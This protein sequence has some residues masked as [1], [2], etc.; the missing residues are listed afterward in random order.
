MIQ[1]L[2]GPNAIQKEGLDNVTRS[3]TKT[4]FKYTDVRHCHLMFL[5]GV[6]N[7]ALQYI[8]RHILRV[9]DMS[10]TIETQVNLNIDGSV[11]PQ[12][13]ELIATIKVI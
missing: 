8:I 6:T 2:I 11:E 7:S 13:D 10:L 9:L 12:D 1:I 3:I 4:L 5:T